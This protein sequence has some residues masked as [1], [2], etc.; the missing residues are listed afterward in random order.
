MLCVV[1]IALGSNFMLRWPMLSIVILAICS[2][3]HYCDTCTRDMLVTTY[4][5]Q[6]KRNKS[7]I[8]KMQK[9]EIK[10]C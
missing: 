4:K 3:I 9:E 2:W 1:S 6:L 7:N 10:L 5:K 8:N